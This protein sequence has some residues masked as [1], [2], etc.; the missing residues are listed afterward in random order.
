MAFNSAEYDWSK[1]TVIAGGV[2]LV[3]LRGIKFSR[4][5]ELEPVHAKGAD[6]HSIQSGNNTYDVEITMLQSQ[7]NALEAA[8]GDDIFSLN[9]DVQVSFGMIGDAIK[10]HRIL[11]FRVAEDNFEMKQ[12]DKFAEIVVPGIARKIQKNV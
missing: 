12:G 1:V 9:M 8:A 7:F 5:R 11:G 10:T 6:P 3:G 4:K 2:D